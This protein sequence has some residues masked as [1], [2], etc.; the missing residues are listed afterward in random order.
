M[1]ISRAYSRVSRLTDRSILASR[2]KLAGFLQS[3]ISR[4]NI[5]TSRGNHDSI[6]EMQNNG[7]RNI[8]NIFIRRRYINEARIKNFGGK[9]GREGRIGHKF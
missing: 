7:S 8:F 2:G 6:R 5:C 1:R 4:F 9:K 3:F